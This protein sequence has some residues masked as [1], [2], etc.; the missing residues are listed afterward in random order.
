LLLSPPGSGGQGQGQGRGRGRRRG[1]GGQGFGA[2]HHRQGGHIVGPA[3]NQAN[4]STSVIGAPATWPSLYNPW[5][6]MISMYPGP[7]MGELQQPSRPQQQQVFLTAPGRPVD[8]SQQTTP[9]VPIPVLAQ[10]YA[11]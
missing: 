8:L 3:R 2:N 10:L 11:A 9:L 7:T 4:G 6:G 1:K 5:T